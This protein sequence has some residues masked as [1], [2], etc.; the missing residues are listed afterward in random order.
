MMN[1]T[2]RVLVANKYELLRQASFGFTEDRLVH[3]QGADVTAW[4]DECTGDLREKIAA[5][6]P[7]HVTTAVLHFGLLRCISLQCLAL[8]HR[9]GPRNT[10]YAT[11]Q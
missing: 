5:A 3:L 7:N 8:P 4:T 11:P 10:S 2:Q 9:S 6:A 1:E